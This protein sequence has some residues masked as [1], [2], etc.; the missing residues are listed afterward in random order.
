MKAT[1]AK[2]RFRPGSYNARI[3]MKAP[4]D[5]KREWPVEDE[6]VEVTRKDTT[7]VKVKVGKV[8]WAGPDGEKPGVE[9]AIYAIKESLDDKRGRA[10]PGTFKRN[11]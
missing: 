3:E 2:D 6:V 1:F 7:T 11:D 4:E 10:P 9:V 5:D 8:L